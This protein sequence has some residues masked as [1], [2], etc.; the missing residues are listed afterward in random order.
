MKNRFFYWVLFFSQTYAIGQQEP[1]QGLEN[2]I[3]RYISTLES[4][5]RIIDCGHF[6]DTPASF[7]KEMENRSLDAMLPFTETNKQQ[8]GRDINRAVLKSNKI[9]KDHVAKRE[10]LIVVNSLVNSMSSENRR[11][12]ELIMLDS[13]IVN[14]FITFGGYIYLTTGLLDFVN[15]YDEL[16]FILGH[17]IGHEVELHTQR[18]ITKLMVSSNIM[19]KVNLEEYEELAIGI[20][21]QVSA[22]FSQIDEYEADYYGFLLAEKAGYDVNRFDDFFEKLEKY[23]D[24][25]LLKKM[26]STHPFAEDRKNCLREY[27]QK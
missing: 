1:N 21:T 8:L 11:D 23:E 2:T 26:T 9:V 12:F 5:S 22:P 4:A 7:V 18:K 17:E 25:N 19:N 10:I 16:A 14:A 13:E 15:T 3:E 24:K 20:N 6:L 27:I